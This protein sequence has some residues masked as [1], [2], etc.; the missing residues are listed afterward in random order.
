MGQNEIA[1]MDELDSI[2]QAF[3]SDDDAALMAASGQQQQQKQTGLP[4]LNINYDMETEDGTALTRGDWKVYIDGKFLYAPEVKLRPI[5]RTFEYSLWD[6]EEGAFICKSVQKPSISGEFPDTEGGNK[7][8]RLPRDQEEMASE[9][10]QLRSRAV[11]CNQ[12]IYGQ[13][14]GDFKAADGTEVSLD[15]HP[16]VAYFK[17]SGFKPIGDFIDSLSRQKKLMQRCMISL[18]TSR[19]KK[20]SVTYWVPSP[21]L[22]S[23]VNISDKDKELMGMFAET[24]S[25]HNNYVMEKHREATKLIM[26]DSDIDLADDFTDVNAA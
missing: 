19:Q 22:D 4:R 21:S 10:A 6:Q 17:K 11:V 24:V 5:L 23:E 16:V 12:V 25:A 9:E 13:I 1:V 14:S 18:N 26:S 15:A 7:C 8:G 20:G 3:N 2:V